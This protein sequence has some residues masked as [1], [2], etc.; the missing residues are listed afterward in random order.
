M[1]HEDSHVVVITVMMVCT[2]K[3]TLFA[4]EW[5]D[6]IRMVLRVPQ[7]PQHARIGARGKG[8]HTIM[9]V[10]VGVYDFQS[11]LVS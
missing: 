6:A 9:N 3:A 10:L 1:N 2:G 7:S 11:P 5:A 4:M 8:T